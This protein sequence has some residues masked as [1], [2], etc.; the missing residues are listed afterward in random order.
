MAGPP[1]RCDTANTS[2]GME[3]A[4]RSP[5]IRI[6]SS[7]SEPPGK[8]RIPTRRHGQLKPAVAGHQ[9]SLS[10]VCLQAFLAG[11]EHG[12]PGAVLRLVEDLLQ[13]VC[14]GFERNLGLEED[15]TLAGRRVHAIN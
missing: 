5:P 10:A 11:D 6:R 9:Q 12:N 3:T 4:S 8:R 14:A 13:F 15:F 7:S 1:S 2:A